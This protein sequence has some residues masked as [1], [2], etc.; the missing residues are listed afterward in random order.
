MRYSYGFGF[1]SIHIAENPEEALSVIRTHAIELIITAAMRTV[2]IA[3]ATQLIE[4]L[5][6]AEGE[7]P[8][9]RDIPAIMVTHQPQ[10][11]D[12]LAARDAGI[13]EF[14][15]T[16]LEAKALSQRIIRAV[17]TPRV[18]VDS[19]VFTGPCRRRRPLLCGEL[20]VGENCLQGP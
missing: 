15:A 11:Q 12:V 8:T 18:F 5:R 2:D 9:R 17:D 6:Q 14:M 1:R 13:S 4:A 19:T 3:E 10:K 7:M 20:N 16:P